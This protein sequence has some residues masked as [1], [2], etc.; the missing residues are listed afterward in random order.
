MASA[1]VLKQEVPS[2][3]EEDQGIESEQGKANR[4]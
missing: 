1:K 4:G 2:E 3:Q